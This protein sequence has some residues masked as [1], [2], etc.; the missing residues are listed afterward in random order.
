M[1]AVSFRKATRDDIDQIVDIMI[2][3][4]NQVSTQVGMKLFGIK[5]VSQ[6]KRLFKA[7]AKASENWRTT[8]LAEM[9]G[10]V[11]GMLQVSEGSLKMTVGVVGTA[12]FL[13][14]PFFMRKLL[15]RIK[16]Q[17]RV[18]TQAPPDAYKIAELHVAPAYRG[19]GI[20][21][22]LLTYAE[23]DA[24][25]TSH[26]KMA[27]QTWTSNPAQALYERHGF[28]ITNTRTDIQFEQLTGTS[29]NHLMVKTLD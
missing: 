22:K 4:P 29:G 9:N 13:Y 27:L 21:S 19:Q 25:T 11:V 3:D 15:P 23:Q 5:T 28:K 20:G 14:G 26:T 16:L 7:M 1:T 10:D 2:G 6:A 12:V 18:Q 8:T 17:Q 24:R